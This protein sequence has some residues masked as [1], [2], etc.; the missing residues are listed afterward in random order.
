M[1]TL[2]PKADFKAASAAYASA[3]AGDF[4]GML[5]VIL[6]FCILPALLEEFLFRG[7]ITAEYESSGIMTAVCMSGLL[8]AMMHLSFVRLPAYFFSG[9][10]LC[11]TMY[12]TRSVLAPM[13]VHA[14]NNVAALWLDR[15]L[16]TAAGGIGERG[17]LLVFILFSVL[18]FSLICFSMS[19][20]KIYVVYGET[21]TPSP[22]VPKKRRGEFGGF[23]SAVLAPPF[24][25]LFVLFVIFTA[26]S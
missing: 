15:Y 19:A 23:F 17:T 24:I 2:F 13:I 6:A 8:F 10:I 20:Q 18:F 1:I 11:L 22:Y 5:Y 14:A 9:V 16:Y 7:I 3:A 4:V 25:F 21:N 12:A 26:V